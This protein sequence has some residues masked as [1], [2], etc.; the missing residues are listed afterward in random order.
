M[1]LPHELY[2]LVVSIPTLARML[3]A[4]RGSVLQDWVR[5]RPELLRVPF[6]GY[7]AANRTAQT[8]FL[9]IIDHCKTVQAIGGAIEFPLEKVK[10]LFELHDGGDRYRIT[11]D[12]PRWLLKEGLMTLSLW[13][14]I[15][16]IFCMS[17]CLSSEG[18][19]RAAYIG[20]IQGRREPEMLDRYRL[21]TRFAAGMRPRDYLVEV[22][23]MFCRLLD[24]AGIKAVTTEN[25]YLSRWNSSQKDSPFRLRYDEIW[26][27]RGG[28]DGG[29][30]FYSLPV[31]AGR[32]SDDEIP[33]KKRA[34]YRQRYAFLDSIEVQMKNALQ[35]DQRT[36]GAS[37]AVTDH[38]LDN[39]G[40]ITLL[41]R[42]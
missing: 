14:D 30:G 26:R 35:S 25:H 1:H 32:R 2:G 24:V 22:F 5:S 29:E 34:M 40:V 6:T 42:K 23:K 21:F 41:P 15:D 18:G 12:H 33:A 27:E 10:D 13:H 31:E 17:F 16:R 38:A 9:R 3:A 11:L 19:K 28:V 4:P 7:V 37:A 8:R 36:S 39:R 20:G